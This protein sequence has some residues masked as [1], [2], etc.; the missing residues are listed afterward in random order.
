MFT[1]I[2]TILKIVAALAGAA[3]AIVR[4]VESIYELRKYPEL[5]TFQEIVQV[6]KNFFSL[7][8][9][10]IVGNTKSATPGQ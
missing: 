1:L 6:V 8:K 3:L 7:E 2:L 5:D 10:E 4:L 9:Y